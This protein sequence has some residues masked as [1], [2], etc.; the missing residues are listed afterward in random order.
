VS[1]SPHSVANAFLEIA[2]KH[3]KPLTNMQV[4]KLV[5][6]AH[7][8][9]LAIKDEPLIDTPVKAWNFG[10]V[11]SP[12]YKALKKYGNGVVTEK[13][14]RNGEEVAAAHGEWEDSLFKRVW[15]VYGQ[16]TGGQMSTLTHQ[17]GSPWA[18]TFKES[19]FGV[20]DDALIAKHFKAQKKK[21]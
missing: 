8:W 17:E 11:I 5:Y 14:L 10:P 6:F 7:G 2:K 13:V 3:N 21:Q 18:V 4:Q 19:P 9:N 20:I 1:F 12:L 15:E 16:L